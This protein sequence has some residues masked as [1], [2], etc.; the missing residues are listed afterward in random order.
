MA[1]V[2][3]MRTKTNVHK[4]L[5]ACFTPL[6][7]GSAPTPVLRGLR[8][9][10]TSR[11][12]ISQ[13]APQYDAKNQKPTTAHVG[14]LARVCDHSGSAN[15]SV[16]MARAAVGLPGIVIARSNIPAT[17]T[18]GI[19]SIAV[20]TMPRGSGLYLDSPCQNRPAPSIM[21]GTWSVRGKELVPSG[22]KE[23]HERPNRADQ[24]AIRP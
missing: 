14:L 24:S 13:S 9:N 18:H 21:G 19:G 6:A 10:D 7:F 4:R 17:T 2:A 16:A 8:P 12:S 15:S 3:S 23:C 5:R 1:V 22:G 11:D 20:S